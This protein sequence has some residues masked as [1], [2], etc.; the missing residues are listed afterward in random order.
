MHSDFRVPHSAFFVTG[1]TAVGKSDIA[2]ELSERLGAEILNADAF[3]LYAG[4]DL[5]T[6]KPPA[7]SPAARAP[8]SRR[9]VRIV[10]VDERRALSGRGPDRRGGNP[11]ARPA[12]HRGGVAPGFTC[13]P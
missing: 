9:V 6:A 13:G 1:P 3:Q 8:S 4:L 5:L 2:V 12:R 11:G 7:R 10:R